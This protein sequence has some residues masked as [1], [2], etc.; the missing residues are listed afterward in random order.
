MKIVGGS[1][2]CGDGFAPR[3]V[4]MCDGHFTDEVIDTAAVI[5]AAGCFVIPGLIDLHF[6]G[7]VGYD[8]CDGT[9]EAFDAIA[10]YEAA[11]G[12]TALCPATM[13]YPEATLDAIVSAAAVH[14]DAPDAAALVGIN[15]EGPFISS[16]K[17][18]AQNPAYVQV[19]DT[20][21]FRR[22]QASARGLIKL[23]DVAPEVEGAFDFID[24]F[25][26]EVRISV[27]HT[28]ADYEIATQAFQRGARQVTHLYN[29]M[30]SLHHRQPGVIGAAFDADDVMVEVIADG[31]HIHPA[32]VRVAFS[33]FGDD[34]VVLISDSMMATGLSD[35]AYSLGG[36]AVSVRGNRATLA[37]GT[38]AGSVTDLAACVRIAVNDMDIPLASAVKAA[39]IN[40][41]RALGLEKERGSIESGKIAD[42]VVLN[43][44]LTVKHVVVRGLERSL[45]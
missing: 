10:R 25:H 12:V 4:Y 31:V 17:I 40:P 3:D 2:F 9:D 42:A 21:L 24:E 19:P 7:C 16:D 41:A 39:T 33:L 20:A 15:M 1:V 18:G 26:D 36:Q 43:S 32:M 22:L 38:I 11:R 34:R 13:T 45:F 35:G 8:F 44:D 5:D 28:C 23:V 30:P 37:D 29:A 6:H 27:A 14:V